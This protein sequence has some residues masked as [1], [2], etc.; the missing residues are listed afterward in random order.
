MQL[1]PVILSGGSGTRLWPLSREQ[2]PK[3]LLA[4]TGDLT[5]LQSTVHRL[6]DSIDWPG[7][8]IEPP[9]VLANEESRFITVEQL[10]QVNVQPRGIILEPVGRNTAPA[11]TLAALYALQD[12]NDPLLLAMPA[13]HVIEDL[14]AF[15]NAVSLG[16]LPAQ[17]GKLAT[18]G[19]VPD[20]PETGYGYIRAAYPA[21]ETYFS[22]A[23][24]VEKPD[25]ATAERYVA[26]GEYFWNS[27][28]YMVKASEWIKLIGLY[29]REILQACKQSFL[30]ASRDDNFMW[31]APAQFAQCPSDS[32]D[33]AVMEKISDPVTGQSRGIVIPM[34]AGWSDLGA[35][36]ALLDIGE[37]DSDGNLLSNDVVALRSRNSLV[38][39]GGR[40]VAC[41]GIDNMIV[42]ETPDAV[43]VAS[44]DR[45]DHVRELVSILKDAG[46]SEAAAHR[47]IHR[48]WGNYDSIDNGVRF[49]VKRI[50][51]NPGASLS[52]QMHYHRAEHWIVVTGTARVTR[53][54]EVFILAENQSTY[55]PLGTKHRLENPG[56]VPLEIIEVQSGTYL[57]EDDIVR[58][59]DNYGR[60]V[61]QPLKIVRT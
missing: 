11:L 59:E 10:R 58:F 13:D 31:I 30:A 24:F 40:L 37:K 61:M 60:N 46:R 52:M 33:Y 41:I 22:I 4:L 35:W 56:I 38:M 50:V 21:S 8:A 44:R 39:S 34:D 26:N 45:I 17:Q 36:S 15:R 9:L 2:Y 42:V 57:G 43:L 20:L 18:F 25:R 1:L 3:Q 6:D 54:D 23:E 47:K 16:V 48:P 7:I 51:V 49:Q 32:I 14:S 5:M 12:G 53:G 19:I 29:R 28:I 55:I 27:G